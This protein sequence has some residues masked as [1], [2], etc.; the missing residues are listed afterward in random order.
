MMKIVHLSNNDIGG[1]GIAT[2]RLHSALLERGHSSSLVTMQKHSGD[3]NGHFQFD[4]A[5][6]LLNKFAVKLGLKKDVVKETAQKYLSGRPKGFEHFSFPFSSLDLT[7]HQH[8]KDADIVHLHWVSD[9]F[10]D[11]KSFFKKIKKIGRAHV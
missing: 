2:V 11:W 3:V 5:G 10:L 9:G 7:A 6:F 4:S 8:V 1:A